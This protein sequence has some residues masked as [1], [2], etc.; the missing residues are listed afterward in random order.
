MNVSRQ[1]IKSSGDKNLD[2]LKN[3]KKSKHEEVNY[4]NEKQ[5]QMAKGDIK[6]SYLQSAQ[7][8]SKLVRKNFNLFYRLNILFNLFNG[9]IKSLY[10][11]MLFNWLKT[12]QI[13]LLNF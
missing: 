9:E 2:N 12:N 5:E 11:S 13:K 7:D 6:E 1:E 4:K 3:S 8:I 10:L